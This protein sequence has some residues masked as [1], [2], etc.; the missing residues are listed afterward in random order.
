MSDITLRQIR[1]ENLIAEKDRK[2]MMTYIEKHVERYAKRWD[3][4]ESVR[5]Y[6]RRK[7][8]RTVV[9]SFNAQCQ[10]T[11]ER[12]ANKVWEDWHKS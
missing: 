8:I 6:K 12:V 2:R 11:V 5:A 7:F 1:E 4:Y 9:A 3:G 10:E